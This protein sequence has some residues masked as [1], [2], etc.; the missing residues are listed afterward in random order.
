M[1][2]IPDF[3]YEH[4]MLNVQGVIE[5]KTIPRRQTSSKCNRKIVEKEVKSLPLKTIFI[6]AYFS[7]LVH[8]LQYNIER[9]LGTCTSIESREV[10]LV[11]WNQTCMSKQER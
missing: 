2:S 4:C 3:L 8:V 11:L 5:R 6:T 1:M 10:K 7:G 9:W